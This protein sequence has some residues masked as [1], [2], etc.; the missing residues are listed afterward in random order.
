MSNRTS[1]ETGEIIIKMS[2]VVQRR[3][4]EVVVG[5]R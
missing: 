5:S 3:K 2:Q 1:S 4:L